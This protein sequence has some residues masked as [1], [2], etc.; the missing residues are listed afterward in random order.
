MAGVTEG[1]PGVYDGSELF[2]RAVPSGV[3]DRIGAGF[4]ALERR[5]SGRSADPSAAIID[6]QSVATLEVGEDGCGCDAGKK[7]EGRKRHL[8]V[9]TD[10]NPLVVQVHAANVQDRVARFPCC[11]RYRPGRE[12]CARCLPTAPMVG[13]SWPLR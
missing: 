12:P 11:W 13:A 4:T 9:D 6:S 1:F 7:I 2:L 8:A 10:G 3:L 5:R